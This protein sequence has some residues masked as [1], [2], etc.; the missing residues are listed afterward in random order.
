[1]SAAVNDMV[2]NSGKVAQATGERGGRRNR[3]GRNDSRG[4][5][6]FAASR[7]TFSHHDRSLPG[8]ATAGPL[9]LPRGPARPFTAAGPLAVAGF[10]FGSHFRSA[11]PHRVVAMKYR[12]SPAGIL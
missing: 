10:F 2:T 6:F 9:F 12:H 1:A 8:C 7:S 4:Y 11:S 5:C 3:A